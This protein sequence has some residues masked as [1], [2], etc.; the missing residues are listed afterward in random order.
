L[1]INFNHDYPGG[2]T[3]NGVATL[4]LKPR[5]YQGGTPKLPK[6]AE[7]GDLI[8]LHGSSGGGVLAQVH[9]GSEL[10]SLWLCVGSDQHVNP[11]ALWKQIQMGASVRGTE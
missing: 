4:S 9:G 3:L 11:S 2:V 10:V 1:T 6:T 7:V 5:S 8:L